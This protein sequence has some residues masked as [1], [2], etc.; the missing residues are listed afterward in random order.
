[1]KKSL[2]KNHTEAIA[3]SVAILNDRD[4]LDR[5]GVKY[6]CLVWTH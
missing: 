1:V 4:I 6:I 2:G 5:D 3:A